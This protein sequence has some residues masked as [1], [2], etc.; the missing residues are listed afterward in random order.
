M[1][2]ASPNGMHTGQGTRGRHSRPRTLI[3]SLAQGK[4]GALAG[5]AALAELML[6]LCPAQAQDATSGERS[7]GKC[8]I[9]HEVGAE[10]K[11]RIGPHLNKVLGR[12]AGSVE[13]YQ[14]S[15]AN[16][17]SAV[18]W[19]EENLSAFIRDPRAYMPGTKMAFA[20]IKNEKELLDLIA[21]LKSQ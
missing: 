16:R 3:P 18:T 6:A 10:A 12:V 5:L 2:R 1:R 9:C 4:L 20:G 21:Y 19:N 8:R 11:N 7:F 17:M 13:G 14:Y 15:T